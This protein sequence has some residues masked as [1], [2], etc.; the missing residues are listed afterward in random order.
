MKHFYNKEHEHKF[1]DS[2]GR[3]LIT[4]AVKQWEC[5]STYYFIKFQRECIMSK[6]EP[7]LYYFRKI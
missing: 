4:V 7:G 1:K 3:S 6:P 2:K 5:S